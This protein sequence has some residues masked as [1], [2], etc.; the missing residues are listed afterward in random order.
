MPTITLR[1]ILPTDL[2]TFYEHQRDPEACR[3][4]AFPS[5]EY[6]AFMAHWARILAD[7]TVINRAVLCDEQLAGSIACY[8]KSG[9][10]EIGYWYGREFWGRGVATRALAAFLELVTERPLHAHVAKHNLGSLR[11][12]QKCGFL[13][14]GEDSYSPVPGG[15]VVE[16]FVLLL[17]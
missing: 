4:A 6:E 10:R 13:V 9:E 14:T 17:E 15:E 5:R 1:D 11:V 16:E 2:P 7:P 3:M 8:G 12:L